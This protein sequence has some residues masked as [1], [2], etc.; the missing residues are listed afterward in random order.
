MYQVVI[1]RNVKT[2]LNVILLLSYDTFTKLTLTEYCTPPINL[3]YT[4][5]VI[6]YSKLKYYR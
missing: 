4:R 1:I 2:Y 3:F 5:K 6:Y